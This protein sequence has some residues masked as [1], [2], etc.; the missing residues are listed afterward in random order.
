MRYF[1]EAEGCGGGA[2][3]TLQWPSA[4]A[5]A[6]AGAALLSAADA[7]DSVAT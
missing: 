3:A 5:G 7:A 1:T 4:G 6:A 2:T